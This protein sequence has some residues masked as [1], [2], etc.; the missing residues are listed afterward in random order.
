VCDKCTWNQSNSECSFCGEFS[1]QVYMKKR[2]KCARLIFVHHGIPP[3]KHKDFM[4]EQTVEI[5]TAEGVKALDECIDDM[6][7]ALGDKLYDRRGA[8]TDYI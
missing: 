2:A 6:L 7:I 1:I 5:R 4:P 3:S 8:L